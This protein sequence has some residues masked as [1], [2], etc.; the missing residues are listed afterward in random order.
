MPSNPQPEQPNPGNVVEIRASGGYSLK[1]RV[2]MPQ[3]GDARA[4]L[5]LLNGVM[6]HSL[7]FHPLIP[8]LLAHGFKLVGADRRG[9]GL[10]QVARGDA[11]SAKVLLDDARV[12]AEHEHEPGRPFHLVGWCWGAVLSINL[13]AEIPGS[14]SS[15]VL[16][17]PGLFP[18]V[19]LKRRMIEEEERAADSLP[20]DGAFL[21]SPIS[22]DMFTTGPAL[23]DFILRD[24]Q[25]LL[26][27][28]PRFHGVMRKLGMAARLVM[29]KLDLPTLLILARQDLATDNAET[30]RNFAKW[31]AGRAVVE[32]V[33]S[34][35]GIQ[36]DA[37]GELAR[38]IAAWVATS[39]R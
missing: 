3:S 15:L 33:E 22:E 27:F 8:S 1:Y 2:W 26:K 4:V 30:E 37:P 12:V 39:S 6:S 16:A 31:T 5:M 25:R 20:K 28:T 7:W 21:T 10:N 19:E 35:H 23:I 13:A 9:T 14:L 17:S 18:T 32:Y 38:L 24:E 34:A 11:P 36:F 29:P